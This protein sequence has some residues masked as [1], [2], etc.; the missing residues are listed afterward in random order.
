MAIL[1]SILFFILSIIFSIPLFLFTKIQILFKDASYCYEVK[2]YVLIFNDW[3]KDFIPRNG[4]PMM[5]A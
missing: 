2:V 3:E 4:I 5:S 1:L